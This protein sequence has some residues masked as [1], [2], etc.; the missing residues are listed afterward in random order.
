MKKVK[1]IIV[2]GA[3]VLQ[4]GVLSF[5]L[6]LEEGSAEFS[7]SPV[8]PDDLAV[9][10]YTSGTTGPP[11]GVMLSHWNM[12]SCLVNGLPSW[13]TNENDIYL[14]PLPLNHIYGMLMVNECNLTGARLIIHKW[15]DPHLVLESITKH[16]VTQ[17]VGVPTMLI[18]LLEVYDSQKHDLKSIRRW[19]SAAAPLSVETLKAVERQLGGRVFEG[20][21]MTEAAPTIA[22]QREGRP[23]KPGSVGPAIENVEVDIFSEDDSPLPNGQEG[24]VCARGPNVMI[25][26][27]N[28]P[29]ETAEALQNGWLHTGDLGILDQDG[30]LFITGRKKD[31]PKSAVGKVLKRELR[32]LNNN[33]S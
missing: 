16:K 25:G 27:L 2:V 18:K 12:C 28:K 8:A 26:Y 9:L 7:L 11:K 24:E 20:Y 13:P 19:I 14:I 6:L 31:L 32:L 22:R 29:R 15:F 23:K 5:E 1:K 4:D 10:M 17:F 30:D 21:G 3:E 33:L